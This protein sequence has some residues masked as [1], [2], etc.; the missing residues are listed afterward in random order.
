[1][2]IHISQIKKDEKERLEIYCHEID[3]EVTEIVRFVK[4]RQ[5]QLTGVI[6]GAQY[7]IPVSDVFYIEGVDNKVFIYCEKQVYETRQK[8]YELEEALAEKYFLRVSKSALVNLIKIE[9][10][11][12]SLNGRFTAV[13]QNGEQVIVSRKYVPELKKALKGEER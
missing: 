8:L 7:E 9:S 2:I 10:I 3:S 12:A 1:M 11:K 5:G 13:L 4:S 6:E